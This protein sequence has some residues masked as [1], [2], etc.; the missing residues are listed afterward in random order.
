MPEDTGRIRR[1]PRFGS[2]NNEC[3]ELATGGRLVRDSIDRAGAVLRF[4]SGESTAF[5]AGAREG[6]FG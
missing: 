4:T 6:E 3:A 5:L 1:T 2:G